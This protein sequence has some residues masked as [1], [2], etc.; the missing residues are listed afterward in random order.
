A[1]VF[2]PPANGDKDVKQLQEDLPQ[3]KADNQQEP[4]QKKAALQEIIADYNAQY[5]TGHSVSEFDRYYQDVQQR[6]KDQ[7]YPNS[8]L[9]HKHKIDITIVVDML[10]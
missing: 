9:P 5:G 4:E 1:C 10:L 8:D 2:S 3:E 6:I 7:Q